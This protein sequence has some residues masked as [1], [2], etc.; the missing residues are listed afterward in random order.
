MTVSEHDGALVWVAWGMI[1]VHLVRCPSFYVVVT[2]TKIRQ[3]LASS[4]GTCLHTQDCH[5][6]CKQNSLELDQEIAPKFQLGLLIEL[7]EIAL[8]Q[9]F[10]DVSLWLTN[11]GETMHYTFRFEMVRPQFLCDDNWIYSNWWK[12]VQAYASANYSY[13]WESQYGKARLS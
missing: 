13:L 7:K 9:G 10:V 5:F 3:D 8:Y 12:K 1:L 2:L 11:N 4:Y 6:W